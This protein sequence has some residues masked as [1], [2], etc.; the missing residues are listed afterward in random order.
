MEVNTLTCSVFI[1]DLTKTGDVYKRTQYKNLSLTLGRNEFNDVTLK[2]DYGKKDMKYAL[3][4]IKLFKKFVKEGKA[5]IRIPD[6]NV[7]FMLSNCPPD[8]LMMFLRTM[9]TKLEIRKQ[10]G[11]IS[12][13][14]KLLS[15][16][17]RTFDEISPLTV[18]DVNTVHE[19]R[20]KALEK[21][22]NMFTPKGKRKRVDDSNKENQPPK[23]VKMARKLV[24][25]VPRTIV[26]VKL[27]K[28]QTHVLEAVSRGRSVFFTGSAG[29]GKSFLMKRIIGKFYKAVL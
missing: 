29:T 13:R 18:K 11:F 1:E 17:P 3:R 5:T 27:S 4:D 20:A 12:D 26:P 9:H 23:G 21:G 16:L 7:Q 2:V 14:K 15:D 28:E 8:K 19:A 10:K 24:T 22:S 25:S 6:R